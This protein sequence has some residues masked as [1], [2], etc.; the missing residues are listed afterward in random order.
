MVANILLDAQGEQLQVV[1][2]CDL[3]EVTS[4]DF[5]PAMQVKSTHL[6]VVF[7]YPL[8][9]DISVVGSPAFSRML[10][11]LAVACLPSSM[12]NVVEIVNKN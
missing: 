1:M 6:G 7:V 12:K 4:L 9:P 11:K 8:P 10:V 2:I 3:S 5:S